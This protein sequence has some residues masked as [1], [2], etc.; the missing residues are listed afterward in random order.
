MST[1]RRFPCPLW[2]DPYYSLRRP[3][4]MLA[5]KLPDHPFSRAMV[6]TP[7]DS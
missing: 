6:I 4:V 7:I 5:L 1:S 3:W 2:F